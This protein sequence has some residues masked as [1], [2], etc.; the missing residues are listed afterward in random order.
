MSYGNELMVLSESVFYEGLFDSLPYPAF[1]IDSNDKLLKWNRVLEHIINMRDRDITAMESSD[2]F[3]EQ[4]I[5]KSVVETAQQ[6]GNAEA[7]LA[8]SS[9]EGGP[10]SYRFS[11][12]PI[13]DSEGNV[14]GV[15]GFGIRPGA[16]GERSEEYYKRLF[17]EMRSG[18]ALC[19]IV[20]KDGNPVDGR[21]LEV[22][23]GF[24]KLTGLGKDEIIGKTASEVLPGFQPYWIMTHGEIL[25]YERPVY[26][27]N[28]FKGIDRYLESTAYSP[29]KNRIMSLFRDVT[30]KERVKEENKRL[31]SQIFQMQKMEAVGRLAGGVAHDFN[32]LLT[33]IIGYSDIAL[34]QINNKEKVRE[35][36]DQ[37]RRAA[38]RAAGL[39]KQLLVF[40]RRE[41]VE[42]EQHD[43]NEI[44]ED[45]FKMLNRLLGENVHVQLD[46]SPDLW[47]TRIN[48][49]KVEQVITNLAVN[50]RD[51]M[52]KGGRLVVQTRNVRID[53]QYAKSCSEALTGDYVCISVE[54]TGCGMDKSTL[55]QVFEPF[56]TT[57]Q[58]GEGTGLG[59]AV[60][61]AVVKEHHGWVHAYSE[62]GLGTT[63]RV[64][65]PACKEQYPCITEDNSP[66][67]DIHGEDRPILL[68]EDDSAICKFVQSRLTERGFRV[69]SA[70][71]V[72]E[73]LDILRS[74]DEDIE[75]IFT[76]VVLPDGTGMD[77][78][79]QVA[80]DRKNLRVIITSG[81]EYRENK[82]TF[83]IGEERVTFIKKPYTLTD[84][85]RA[86]KKS[87]DLPPEILPSQHR[88][89]EG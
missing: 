20:Y 79:E 77:L 59:L 2:L 1:V 42:F 23:K 22:N 34:M 56:F 38:E 64:Y 29:S 21:F 46:L 54:D 14:H 4:G 27:I 75:L 44:I 32:N 36:L 81:Y 66:A 16:T 80:Q 82:W 47:K 74:G 6:G 83:S 19:E 69:Y 87:L 17:N 88:Q 89:G 49:S 71:T 52:D 58:S 45:I 65:F 40:S 18:C 70:E 62:K 30:E 72:A 12:S 7:D 11:F 13:R 68:V 15:F 61:Y 51:A 35:H 10:V 33:A 57:K 67:P 24:E 60:V 5:F 76:D 73:A 63:F 8:L 85:L 39:T 78:I 48:K 53:E 9:A 55:R 50:A 25:H 37:L 84:L 31:Q 86:V 43:L 41:Q 28:H 3:V 26:S